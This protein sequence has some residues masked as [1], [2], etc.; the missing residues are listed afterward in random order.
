MR[1]ARGEALFDDRRDA[2]RKLTDELV[3]YL[4][5]PVVVLGIPNGGVT[6]ALEVARLLKADF[7]FVISRKI[8]LPFNTEAGL[9]SITDDG[10]MIINEEVVAKMGLT[11]QQI[12]DQASEVRTAIRQRTLLYRG[13]RPLISVVGKTA[14]IIDDGLATG[15]TMMAAVQSVRRRR[16]KEVIAAVPVA[17]A[18][19]AKLVEE[20]AD[21][22]VTCF[23]GSSPEFYLSDFYR[24]WYEISDDEVVRSI[25]EWRRERY[26]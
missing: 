24:Q 9:G 21:R 26:Y 3:E 16:P 5:Q 1:S 20:K 22:V 11:Q 23:T 13:D 15:Y 10:T 4:D 8:P 7:E 2:G 6:I 25:R 14:I 17:S 18:A 19:A 12:H